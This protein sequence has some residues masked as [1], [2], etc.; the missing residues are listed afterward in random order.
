MSLLLDPGVLGDVDRPSRPVRRDAER[1]TR[2]LRKNPHRRR[3]VLSHVRSDH[4]IIRSTLAT[5]AV[6]LEHSGDDAGKVWPSQVRVARMLGVSVRTVQRHIREL[7]DAGYLLVYPSPPVRDEATGQYRRKRTNRYYFV[8]TKTPGRGRR[9]AR[10][11]R[12]H[13]HD[14]DGVST[15]YVVSNPRPVD[16]GGGVGSPS[17][18]GKQGLR[19]SS[20]RSW[21]PRR[22]Q[23]SSPPSA[24]VLPGALPGWSNDKGC[25][26]CDFTEWIFD[27]AGRTTPCTCSRTH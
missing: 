18:S 24:P 26:T 4:S 25:A 23:G 6:L 16:G 9:R 11:R 19:P 10:S 15:T 12:S 20:R 5:F 3:Q 22:R 7:R 14:T 2:Q 21:V 1:Q 8:F 27:E 17:S 13:L